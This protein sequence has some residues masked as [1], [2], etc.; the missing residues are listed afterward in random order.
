MSEE[1]IEVKTNVLKLE[2]L[3]NQAI[4]KF[5]EEQEYKATYVEIDAALMNI[6]KKNNEYQ[7]RGLVEQ[8]EKNRL[9]KMIED[10]KE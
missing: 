8:K 5:C 3:L 1:S 10:S 7:L 6:L 4:G 2:N 9:N